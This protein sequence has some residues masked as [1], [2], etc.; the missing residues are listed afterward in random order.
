MRTLIVVHDSGDA[1]IVRKALGLRLKGRRDDVQVA[2]VGQA[3]HGVGY[4][5]IV[6]GDPISP[7]A[8][9][10]LNEVLRTRLNN[11]KSSAIVFL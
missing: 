2:F 6:M 11:P 10:Y 8:E 3:L 1:Q 9:Q 5:L 7:L 4:D